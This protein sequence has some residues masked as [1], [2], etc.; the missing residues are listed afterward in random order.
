MIE[1]NRMGGK[2]M[3]DKKILAFF[4]ATIMLITSLP[5]QAFAA[6]REVF[7]IDARTFP[8]PQLQT[9]IQEFDTDRNRSIDEDELREARKMT[10][11]MY[12]VSKG[13]KDW[14]GFS[15]FVNLEHIKAFKSPIAKN[16]IKP[17]NFPKATVYEVGGLIKKEDLELGIVYL[18]NGRVIDQHLNKLIIRQASQIE[19]IYQDSDRIL[20]LELY[21][22]PKLRSLDLDRFP[23]ISSLKVQNN[24]ALTEIT[25]NGKKNGFLTEV[26]CTKNPALTKIDLSGFPELKTVRCHDN[27]LNDLNVDNCSA[28]EALDCDNNNLTNLDV[29]KVSNLKYLSCNTNRLSNLDTTKCTK[30]QILDCS[31][32]QLTKLDARNSADIFLLCNNNQLTNDNLL[33][34]VNRIIKLDCSYNQLTSAEKLSKMGRCVNLDFS[35]N[36]VNYISVDNMP[37]LYELRCNNNKNL[38]GI[39]NMGWAKSLRKVYCN[40]CSIS[41]I[42]IIDKYNVQLFEFYCQNNIIDKIVMDTGKL[43]K[44]DCSNNWLLSLNIDENAPISFFKA[45]NQKVMYRRGENETQFELDGSIWPSKISDLQNATLKQTTTTAYFEYNPQDIIN[46]DINYNYTAQEKGNLTLR[47]HLLFDTANFLDEVV[48]PKDP[49]KPDGKNPDANKYFTVKFESEDTAKGTVAAEN[50]FYILKTAGKTLADLKNSAP[51]ATALGN[52]KFD[53]WEPSLDANTAID[54]DRTVK[55]KFSAKVFDPE[56]VESMVVK[57][58]PTKLVYTEGEKLALAGLVVTLTDNQGLTKDVAFADF[59]DNGITAAPANDTALTLANNAK[60]V[61]LTKGSLTAETEALTVK[62]KVFDPE[63]VVKM[64]IMS[65][66]RK[67]IYTEGEKLNLGGLRVILTDNQGIEKYVNF[68]H[69]TQ[70]YFKDYGVTTNPKNGDILSL[71]NNGKRL[72]VTKGSLTK[73]AGTLTVNAKVVGPVDPTQ[74]DGGKPADT[75]KYWTVTFV[76]A[77]ETKGTVAAKNTVYVLKTET[78]K[79]ADIADKAPAATALGNN[80]FDGWDPALDTNTAIDQDRTVKAQ[81]S[82]KVF[83]SEH[84]ESMVVKTQPTKLSYTEGEKLDLTGLVVTLTDNQGVTKDVAFA[85]FTANGITAKPANDTELKLADSG[86]KVTLTKGSLTAT[87]ESLTVNAKVFDPAHVEK[88]VV[89]TQPKLSYTEGEK[90]E[91]AGL[92][93]TLTDNQNLTKDVAFA[94]FTA[95]GITAE[96]AND[97]ELKLADSGK[98]VTLTKESLTAETEA[99]TVKAKVFDPAHV[100][101]MVVKEQPTKLIYTEGEKLELAGL[102]VTLT[103]N[104]GLTK[105]VTFADFAANGITANPTDGT[106]LKLADNKT[107]V[108]LT[109]GSLQDETANLIVNAK[110]TPQDPIVGP[111][112]PNVTPNPDETKNWTVTFAADQTKGTIGKANTFYVPKAAGKTLADLANDAPQVTA[113]TGFRFTGWNPALEA[114]TAINGN[115]TINAEFET[116]TTPQDPKV[117]V[118][119]PTNPGTVPTGRVRVTFDAGEGNTIDGKNRYKYLDVLEN[120]AWTDREVTDEIPAKAKYKDA[121]QEFDKWDKEVPTT[122]NVEEK[123]FTAIYTA[124]SFDLYVDTL[125]VGETGITVRTSIPEVKI[126]IIK[127]GK[128]LK[129]AYT[130]DLGLSTIILDD[131]TKT[132]ENY[133]IKGEKEGYIS[134]EVSIMVLSI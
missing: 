4:L 65:R 129:E 99:L 2:K 9:L 46:G 134:K 69:A 119:D 130:N 95:N 128:V 35:Y 112:D 125:S 106:E 73:T 38:F 126:T 37:E 23:R 83:D 90:L 10:D 92:V 81:F 45:D 75:S 41:G 39:A 48:G 34:D 18:P 64:K 1:K 113:K 16:F 115:M 105:D 110:V 6:P 86:K 133:Q 21:S 60:T 50:T 13:V 70:P 12:N 66:P 44:I 57:T 122:G 82:A 61:K 58:Q 43:E 89:K 87:T 19:D 55:A 101:K 27:A 36:D 54:K 72:T 32:N 42:E 102:V 26:E 104:Q 116:T 53:G 84:V 124:K 62:A 132:D 103:D 111:V 30:L 127:G 24:K 79:L 96:P 94:D 51:A 33:F 74:P 117:V 131:Y 14:T 76:S 20:A 63:H 93:V 67:L 88:M 3:K 109:K 49:T 25:S 118:P 121:T 114:S 68:D 78:K 22:V 91:L 100:E 17:S 5:L 120:T 28:L 123:I 47:P 80:K 71:D 107:P 52:N 56:H 59:A 40:D 97:T 7:Q 98:K 85:D 11:R 31:K 108:T 15:R 29:S 77:D 8:D